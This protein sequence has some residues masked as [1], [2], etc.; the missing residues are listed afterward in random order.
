[1]ASRIRVSTI[2]VADSMGMNH[3]EMRYSLVS[4]ELIADSIE[5][6]MYA[7]AYDGLIG[8]AGCD[9]T[10]FGHPAR[11]V[12]I[13]RHRCSCTRGR[14]SRSVRGRDVGIVD[15][16]EGVG[17]VYSGEL[18]ESELLELERCSIPTLGSCA[19]QF[20]ANTMAMVAEVLALPCPARQ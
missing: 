6:V 9:K 3:A 1:M 13:N 4:R 15:V 7:H 14:P 16:Y 12:R 2:T 19:G 8:F 5:A 18:K 17:R 11:D 10:L 20:T